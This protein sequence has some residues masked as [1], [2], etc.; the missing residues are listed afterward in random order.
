MAFNRTKF[1]P[2]GGQSTRGSSPQMFSYSTTDNKAT[3]ET[4]GYFNGAKTYL[5]ANDLIVACYPNGFSTYKVTASPLNGDIEIQNTQSILST[6]VT[7]KTTSY[8]ALTADEI[9]L[10]DATSGEITVTLHTAITN[11]GKQLVIKKI[12]SSNNQVILDG[13]GSETIDGQT[14]IGLS[15]QYDSLT[16]ISDDNNWNII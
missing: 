9:I 1:S 13:L 4:T 14:T 10:C 11:S 6:S 8:T 16:L 7:T 15:L 3:I 2:V 5:E 12:D